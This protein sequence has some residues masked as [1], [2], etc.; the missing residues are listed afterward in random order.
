MQRPGFLETMKQKVQCGELKERDAIMADKG[1][2]IGDDLAK[3]KLKLNIPPFLRDKVG[4][5]GLDV[6]KT[7]T[8]AHH[9]IHVQRAIMKVRRFK[10]FHSV[11]PVSMFGSINQIGNVVCFLSNFLNPVLSKDEIS[12]KTW[13]LFF[14]FS[15]AISV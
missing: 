15:L 9:R 4:F 11:I 14:S 13:E 2:D 5:E 8:I 10:I 1:F 3:V 12:P 6:I 7:Q